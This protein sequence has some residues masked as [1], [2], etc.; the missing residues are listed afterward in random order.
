MQVWRNRKNMFKFLFLFFFSC[1]FLLRFFSF[2]LKNCTFYFPIQLA[3]RGKVHLY[4]V[5]VNADKRLLNLKDLSLES[6]TLNTQSQKHWGFI[7]RPC[8]CLLL[9]LQ[10]PITACLQV[11]LDYVQFHGTHRLRS[12]NPASHRRALLVRRELQVFIMQSQKST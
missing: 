12:Q 11:G 6:L 10:H 7:N 4:F 8:Q 5:S 2:L 3:G 1:V 9:S